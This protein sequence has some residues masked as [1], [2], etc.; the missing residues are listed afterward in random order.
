MRAPRAS[1]LQKPRTRRHVVVIEDYDPMKTIGNNVKWMQL[2][3]IV[4]SLSKP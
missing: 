1:S 2:T 4:N 3:T